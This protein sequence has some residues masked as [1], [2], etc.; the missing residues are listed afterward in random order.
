MRDR[1][2]RAAMAALLLFLSLLAVPAGRAEEPAELT[3]KCTFTLE[4]KGSFSVKEVRDNKYTTYAALGVNR[5]VLIAAKG[6]PL[7]SLTLRFYDRATRTEVWAE[8]NGEWELA[9]ECGAHLSHWVALPEGTTRVRVKNTDKARALFA[10]MDVYAPGDRPADSPVWQDLPRADLMV[11]VC[12]PDDEL[13]WLGGLLP[14]YAGER[15]R[16][17]LV[18]YAVPSTPRR[19]LELLD[20]LWHCGVTGY[21]EFLGRP[22]VYT[23]TLAGAYKKW[24]RNTMAKKVTAL[25][26]RYHPL[27]VVTHDINGEY[28]HGGHRAVADTVTGSVALAA[29]AASF[30]DS[31]EEYGVWQV[32][33]CYVHLYPEGRVKL[34]WHVPLTAFGGKD[35]MAVAREAM[36]MH[37]SQV[38]H[39]WAIEEGGDCDNTL[40]GLY[41]TAVGA[42]ERGD[43]LFEHTE[44]TEGD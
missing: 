20:G 18:V 4:P 9:A 1:R 42:D 16:S 33:K 24:G 27:V 2:I 37:V 39:G 25:I 5:S 35:G 15:G 44:R 31:A 8:R 3:K 7:G 40:F 26:R 13:L 12:H 29:D 6:Q 38:R 32:Q 22:D 30:S 43:D 14:T 23:K 28:G 10:E 21:P 11:A 36:A 34:D 41:F 19:R 17:T